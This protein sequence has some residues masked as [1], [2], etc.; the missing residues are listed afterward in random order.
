MV[1]RDY[2]E[3]VL[4]TLSAPRQHTIDLIIAKATATLKVIL[5]AKECGVQQVKL[6]GDAFK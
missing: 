4:A 2:E 5:F 3:E 1:V 6:E